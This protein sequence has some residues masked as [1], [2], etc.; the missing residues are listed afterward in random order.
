LD[1]GRSAAGA[2]QTA[3]VKPGREF[4][5]SRVTPTPRPRTVGPSWVRRNCNRVTLS[6]DEHSGGGGDLGAAS[7][8]GHD[9]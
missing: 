9:R 8:L 2:A 1:D 3:G 4:R 6:H 5:Q 7:T